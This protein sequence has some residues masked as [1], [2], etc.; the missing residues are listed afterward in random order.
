MIFINPQ[1]NANM[2]DQISNYNLL[3]IIQID[4]ALN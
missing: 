1:I 2:N 3:R 4:E